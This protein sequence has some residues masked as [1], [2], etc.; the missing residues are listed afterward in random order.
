M[1]ACLEA[2]HQYQDLAG[3]AVAMSAGFHVHGMDGGRL[4]FALRLKNRRSGLFSS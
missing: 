3:A 2:A 1:A 4:L